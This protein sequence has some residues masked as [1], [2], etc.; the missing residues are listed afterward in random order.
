MVQVRELYR[1]L[2]D[3][4][5]SRSWFMMNRRVYGMCELEGIEIESSVPDSTKKLDI[6]KM[7]SIVFR[8]S[9]PKDRMVDM[10]ASS[11]S[12]SHW[13]KWSNS[14]KPPAFCIPSWA[15]QLAEISSCLKSY[16]GI[17]HRQATSITDRFA[18]APP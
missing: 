1:Y 3:A 11:T 5:P 18:D 4:R 9:A 8:G 2:N 16:Q 6:E 12:C 15:Q 14:P 7:R 13:P 10:L 17:I